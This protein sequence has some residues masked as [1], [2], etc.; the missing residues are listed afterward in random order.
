MFRGR[1]VGRFGVATSTGPAIRLTALPSVRG[2]PMHTATVSV[3][4]RS[5]LTPS[6]RH[7]DC[8]L[9]LSGQP[10]GRKVPECAARCVIWEFGSRRAENRIW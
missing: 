3:G 2:A 5:R 10:Y 8:T 1:R 7:Q 4:S 9:A 6:Q